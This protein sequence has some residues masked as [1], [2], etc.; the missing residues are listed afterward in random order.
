[1]FSFT[2]LHYQKFRAALRNVR[3]CVKVTHACQGKV[4]RLLEK[5]NDV[6]SDLLTF[7]WK[8]TLQVTSIVEGMKVLVLVVVTPLFIA[9][10]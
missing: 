3:G 1:M 9:L 6:K 2:S 7:V 5:K 8:H 10:G 4:V